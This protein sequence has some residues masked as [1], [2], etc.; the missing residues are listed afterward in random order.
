MCNTYIFIEVSTKRGNVF[1]T[2]QKQDYTVI[3]R[4]VIFTGRHDIKLLL[5]TE[6]YTKRNTITCVN[7]CACGE[8]ILLFVTT[9]DCQASNYPV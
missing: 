6:L 7:K 4:P 1:L 8:L 9:P 5:L 3:A 2:T